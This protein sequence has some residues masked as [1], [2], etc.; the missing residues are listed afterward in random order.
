MRGIGLG[1]ARYPARAARERSPQ[2]RYGSTPPDR[3]GATERL[4]ILI[5]EIMHILG[6]GHPDPY[7]FPDTIMV[8]DGNGEQRIR[9][10]PA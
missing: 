7:A 5:H 4:G 3:T 2:A 1:D 10:E 8:A 6:R 9:P